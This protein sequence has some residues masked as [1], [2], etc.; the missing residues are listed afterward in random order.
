M[1]KHS[2]FDRNLNKTRNLEISLSSFSYLCS[3]ML[4]YAQKKSTG[5][6]HLEEK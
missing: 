5:I 4:Q 3:E 1:S 2:I 6:S